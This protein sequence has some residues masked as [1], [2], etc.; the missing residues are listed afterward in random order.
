MPRPSEMNRSDLL[1]VLCRRV[2]EDAPRGPAVFT[3]DE[4]HRWPAD[5][6]EAVSKAGLLEKVRRSDRVEC[7]GCTMRCCRP[8]EQARSS[9]GR[10]PRYFV[11]CDLRDDVSRIPVPAARLARWR[12]DPAKFAAFVARCL[13]LPLPESTDATSF[14]RLGTFRTP[15]LSRAIS[16]E[17]D[18]T[19]RLRVGDARIDITELITWEGGRVRIDPDE[20]G[21]VAEQA[22]ETL[23]GGRRYQ[24][25]R[26]KQRHKKQRTELRNQRLQDAADDLKRD[27]PTWNKT[28]IAEAIVESGEFGEYRHLQAGGIERIIRVRK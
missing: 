3:A 21:L 13:G 23:V 8:V 9:E 12:S 2:V 17:F 18:E 14:V 1:D 10:P 26:V 20:L 19:V 27:H 25:S 22:S 15:R 24:A 5:S 7:R 4:L 11:T 6:L 16:I 28:K